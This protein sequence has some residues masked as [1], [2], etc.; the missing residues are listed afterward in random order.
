MTTLTVVDPT[1]IP[2][3]YI[4]NKIPKVLEGGGSEMKIEFLRKFSLLS[5]QIGL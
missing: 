4:Y 2:A 5:T 3:L 1:S